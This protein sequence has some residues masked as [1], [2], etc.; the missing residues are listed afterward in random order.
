MPNYDV[1]Y[2]VPSYEDGTALPGCWTP[3]LVHPVST[4]DALRAQVQGHRRQGYTELL[5]VQH[6]AG[7]ERG[8]VLFR[9]SP[10]AGWPELPGVDCAVLHPERYDEAL[11][12]W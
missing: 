5:G 6:P 10:M 2:R 1:Y 7:E 4:E 8:A 3:L 9:S 12:E 11:R